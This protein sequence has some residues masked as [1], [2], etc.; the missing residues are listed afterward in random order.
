MC[1][2]KWERLC[3]GPVVRQDNACALCP[4]WLM[5]SRSELAMICKHCIVESLRPPI[6]INSVA[7]E[8]SRD[9]LHTS[10]IALI[11]Q[12]LVHRSPVPIPFWLQRSFHMGSDK[13]TNT[14]KYHKILQISSSNFNLAAGS[15]NKHPGPWLK[16]LQ[17]QFLRILPSRLLLPKSSNTSYHQQLLS[18]C[19]FIAS[20]GL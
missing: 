7:H 19:Q 2:M 11:F 8:T 4:S 20:C 16:E 10:C 5:C 12:K 15:S 14:C 6:L 3:W 17:H 1:I 9:K 18:P 13:Y